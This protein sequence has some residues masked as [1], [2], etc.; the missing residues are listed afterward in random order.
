MGMRILLRLM[1]FYHVLNKD[2]FTLPSK[3]LIVQHLQMRLDEFHLSWAETENFGS[4]QTYRSQC[5]P[6][7]VRVVIG[8]S[9]GGATVA[10]PIVCV[11]M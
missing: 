3:L 11:A 10:F 6:L 5:P 9:V 7:A 1:L 4:R 8:V 2:I